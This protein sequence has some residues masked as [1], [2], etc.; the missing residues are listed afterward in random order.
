MTGYRTTADGGVT[1]VVEHP[2]GSRTEA[3]GRLLI[4]ADGIHSSNSGADAPGTA[5]N[6][7]GRGDHVARH[8]LGQA[9]P[10]RR[11]FVGLGTH[12]HR[13]VF[14]PISPPD[15][16]TGLAMINWIAEITVDNA[17]GW[18]QRGWFRPVG[19]EEFAHHFANWTWDWLD[20][21]ALIRQADSA[22]EI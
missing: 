2:G 8:D 12:R 1:A 6:S 20:V 9:E 17:E 14:Y 18:K 10:H 21:P 13:M 5:A 16:Q 3:H 15:P 11:A 22:F 7:L 4:G 19:I